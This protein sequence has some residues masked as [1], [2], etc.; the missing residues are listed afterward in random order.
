MSRSRILALAGTIL[1]FFSPAL[2]AKTPCDRQQ[3]KPR[4][5][6]Q[7]QGQAISD[8][9]TLASALQNARGGEVYLL[10]PGNY[11]TLKLGKAY[12]SPVV[13]RSADPASL[14]C[15]SVAVLDGAENVH[16]D[17][18]R[19]DYTFK[20]ADPY[21]LA[22]FV[23]RN[24][25]NITISNS[26]FS[27]DVARGTGTPEDGAGFGTGLLVFHAANVDISNSE[28]LT[29][30]KAI[31]AINT[32][33]IKITDSD[34]HSIRSDGLVFDNVDDILVQNNYIHNFGGADGV[35]DHRDMIQIQRANNSGSANITIRDNIFDVGAGDFAQ[36]I[37]AGGDGKNIGD[38]EVR[39]RNVLIEN[40]MI[41]NGHVHGISIYGSDNISVRKNSL[42]NVP[43]GHSVPVIN[44]SPDSTSV[45]IEQNAAAN[46]MGYEN[47]R[48]WVLLNNAMIQDQNPS[49]EGYYDQQFIYHAL[50]R[51]RG[52]NEFGVRPGSLMD[53]LNAGS[54]LAKNY[55]TQ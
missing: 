7:T 39:H 1:L 32:D 42:I 12:P 26:V 10:A 20:N 36:T 41:Y 47:Q 48:D 23:V 33:G 11:G 22:N 54:T 40:N 35:G 52:Y 13:I 24:S 9:A 53:R 5:T 46:I 29:W 18:I 6:A 34:V 55:P 4:F 27:G 8:A 31:I 14:A 28:F 43:G 17:G 2:H 50:G 30:W 37:W 15:F 44:I 38:P 45:V 49:Q 25:R 51:E 19:F 3:F 21:H 16:L